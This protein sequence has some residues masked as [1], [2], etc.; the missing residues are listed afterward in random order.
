[1][2]R[3]QYYYE[4]PKGYKDV[5]FVRPVVFLQ[6]ATG[7]FPPGQF[8]NDYVV[9]MDNDAPQLIRSV[10]FQGSN[11]GQASAPQNSGQIRLRDAFGNYITDGFVPIWLYAWG[12]G[13]TPPDGGS[14]RTKVFEPE[15]YCPPGSVLM[16]DYFNPDSPAFQ[17]PGLIE[18]RGVKRFREDCA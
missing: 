14:G 16:I 8:L 13:E 3:P 18:F 15:L 12:A 2:H 4:T 9:Q 1:M 17:Y 7:D 11:Q 6:D 10:F 5:P